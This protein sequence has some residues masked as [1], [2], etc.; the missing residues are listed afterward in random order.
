MGEIRVIGARVRSLREQRGLSQG[1]LAYKINST[2]GQI[3]RIENNERPGV[4]AVT[5]AA[6]ARVLGTTVEYLLGMT[7]D[8]SPLPEP[9]IHYELT[10]EQILQVQELSERVS[11]MP[12]DRQFAVMEAFLALLELPVVH[13]EE[14]E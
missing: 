7:N 14:G 1:Q 6:I 11:R 13:E 12:L 5:I 8:P 10:P 3:S 4:A 2:S 9:D